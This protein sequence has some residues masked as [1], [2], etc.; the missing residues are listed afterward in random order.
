MCIVDVLDHQADP[1]D[2]EAHQERMKGEEGEDG[3]KKWKSNEIED[4]AVSVIGFFF[5]DQKEKKPKD[6]GH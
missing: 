2:V 6:V 5:V 4:F 3:Y 1:L